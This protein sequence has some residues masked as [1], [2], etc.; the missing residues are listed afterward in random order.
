MRCQLGQGLVPPDA[1]GRRQKAGWD[2]H[3][4]GWS[5]SDGFMFRSGATYDD[6]FPDSRKGNLDY[7]LL[8]HMG[9]TKDKLLKHDAFFFWQL[10]FPICDPRFSKI[11]NDP[12]LPFYSKV[13]KWTQKYA[14]TQGI[15][16]SYGHECKPE[17]ADLVHF[18]MAVVHDG[19]LGGMDGAIYC[20]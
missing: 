8:K 19:V 1:E 14:A 5:Q 16:G 20:R 15:G 11:E 3:Y 13:E 2:F 9:L 4:T 10:L 7:A 17:M 18:N 6:P 12:R